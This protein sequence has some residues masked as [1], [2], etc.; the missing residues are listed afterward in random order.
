MLRVRPE[1]VMEDLDLEVIG[2]RLRHL[3]GWTAELLDSRLSDAPY[4]TV[5]AEIPEIDPEAVRRLQ[6]ALGDLPRMRAGLWRSVD[7][8]MP[9][10]EADGAILEEAADSLARWLDED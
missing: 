6:Q 7:A 10:A 9:L 1:E 2:E 5:V 4:V 8:E 3:E